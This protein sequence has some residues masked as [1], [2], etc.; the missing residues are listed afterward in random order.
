MIRSFLY[1]VEASCHRH[2]KIPEAALQTS[3][4]TYGRFTMPPCIRKAQIYLTLI[5]DCRQR[6]ILT[7]ALDICSFQFL[8]GEP[9]GILS[10]QWTDQTLA[11]FGLPSSACIVSEIM[12]DLVRTPRESI[13]A[14][15]L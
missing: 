1:K 6:L 3:G 7:R 12:K 2:F 8:E 4:L 11:P 13:R 9:S 14:R 5:E 15:A 10:S